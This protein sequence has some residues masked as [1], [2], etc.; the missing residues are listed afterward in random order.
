MVFLEVCR[1]YQF[2]PDR[3]FIFQK[4]RI[5]KPSNR[6]LDLYKKELENIRVNLHEV[7]IE[8]YMRKL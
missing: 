3:L 8:E 5:E 1:A 4:A 7:L 2:I 6:F